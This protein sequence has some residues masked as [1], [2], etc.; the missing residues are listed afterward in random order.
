MGKIEN[1][2]DKRMTR[3]LNRVRDDIFKHSKGEEKINL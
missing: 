3:M 2:N 1:K